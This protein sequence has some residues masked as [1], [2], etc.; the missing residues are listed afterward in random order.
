MVNN[1][2]E[3]RKEFEFSSPILVHF[4][5]ISVPFP[6]HFLSQKIVKNFFI[7]YGRQM[8]KNNEEI[9]K[10]FEFCPILFLF[11][12]LLA[13]FRSISGPFT[14]P[15]NCQEFFHSMWTPNGPD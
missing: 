1:H 11:G 7:A 3:I 6:V 10:E 14:V 8:V 5:S 12:P 2:Q 9:R 13:H 4:C 15:K